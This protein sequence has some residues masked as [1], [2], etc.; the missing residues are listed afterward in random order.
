MTNADLYS[1]NGS[2]TPH[3]RP[4]PPRE[5]AP[6]VIRRGPGPAIVVIGIAILTLMGMTTYALVRN[7]IP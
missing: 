2:R 4:L 7:T 5:R 3:S 6:T 1:R